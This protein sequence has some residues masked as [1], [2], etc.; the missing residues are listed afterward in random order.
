MKIR[1]GLLALAM[2][3]VCAAL[4]SCGLEPDPPSEDVGVARLVTVDYPVK[5]ARTPHVTGAYAPEISVIQSRD[6]LIRYV[7]VYEKCYDF[8]D[9]TAEMFYDVVSGYKEDYFASQALVICVI[10]APNAS[11]RYESEGIGRSGTE[12]EYD[13]R[14]RVSAPATASE[15]AVAWHLFLE[16]PDSSPFLR[17]SAEIHVRYVERKGY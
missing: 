2:L 4:A 14:I 12:G 11:N 3:F 13:L 5:I 6:E 7:S 10:H 16:V 1:A 9:E 8:L 15:E 17:D